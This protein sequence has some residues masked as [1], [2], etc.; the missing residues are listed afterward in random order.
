M[1]VSCMS[2]FVLV[3][4]KTFLLI[5]Y[6]LVFTS[7]RVAL[8]SWSLHAGSVLGWPDFTPRSHRLPKTQDVRSG[9]KKGVALPVSNPQNSTTPKKLLTLQSKQPKS[10]NL[11]LKNL[12]TCSWSS[13]QVRPSWAAAPLDEPW[14][15]P[16][17]SLLK[18]HHELGGISG[19][20]RLPSVTIP[21]W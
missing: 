10:R 9:A 20:Y 18:N 6:T 1:C 4:V 14:S 7:T 5:S 15:L 13:P 21:N 12:R 11:F 8:F 16:T 17:P 2:L 19:Y 3:C